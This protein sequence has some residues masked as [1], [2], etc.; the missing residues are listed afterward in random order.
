MQLRSDAS[1]ENSLR[2]EVQ[3]LERQRATLADSLGTGAM[4]VRSLNQNVRRLSTEVEEWKGLQSKTTDDLRQKSLLINALQSDLAS[5][6]A[7]R[8]AI[9]RKLETTEAELSNV[10]LHFDSLRQQH[11]Q[12]L[13]RTASLEGEIEELSSDLREAESNVKQKEQ[14]LASDRDI[15]ELMG[16]RELYI[17]DV[18]DVESSGDKRKAYGRVFYTKSKSLIFYAFD[19]DQ[20]PKVRDASIF[21]AWGRRGVGDKRPLNMG[22]FYLDNQANRRWVLKFEDPQALAQLD[23]V[24][25]TVEPHGGSKEPSGRQLLFASLRTTPNHP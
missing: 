15:R 23:A 24:F 4:E 17:A 5:K 10:R 13:L 25:V 19:L 3:D 14:F 12:E 8:D 9:G 7:E 21:Q 20:Q 16:A 2:Q 22:V 6:A 11:S 1:H 18:F